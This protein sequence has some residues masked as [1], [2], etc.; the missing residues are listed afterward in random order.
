VSENFRSDFIGINIE[1]AGLSDLILHGK[2]NLAICVL[3][4]V[5]EPRWSRVNEK[6][7]RMAESQLATQERMGCAGSL[8]DALYRL[9]LDMAC[10]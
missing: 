1:G 7:K 10:H 5:V 3:R 2:E 6:A 8:A 9:E 4:I